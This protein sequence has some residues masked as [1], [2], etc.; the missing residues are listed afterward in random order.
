MAGRKQ[1]LDRLRGVGEKLAV[2]PPELPADRELVQRLLGV[3]GRT[4]LRILLELDA[5][6][7]DDGRLALSQAFFGQA[8]DAPGIQESVALLQARQRGAEDLLGLQGR[9]WRGPNQRFPLVED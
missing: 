3:P 7:D 4:A 5:Q 2:L 1:W 8:L 9:F 6:K